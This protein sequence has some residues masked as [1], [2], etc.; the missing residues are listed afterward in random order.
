MSAGIIHQWGNRLRWVVPDS[1]PGAAAMP[2]RLAV[3][4]PEARRPSPALWEQELGATTLLARIGPAQIEAVKLKR[5]QQVSRATVD[6]TLAVLKPVF[7]WSIAHGLAANNPVRRVK[8]F[9]ED[10]SRL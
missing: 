2:R 4:L 7:N 5:A 1:S 10:N 3:A 8:L 9:H 6:K